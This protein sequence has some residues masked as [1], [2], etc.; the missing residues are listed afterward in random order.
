MPWWI[1]GYDAADDPAVQ[2]E[3]A[4]ID[5]MRSL[6]AALRDLTGGA[7][8]QPEPRLRSAHVVSDLDRA[9]AQKVVRNEAR[10]LGLLVRADWSP[11]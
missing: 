4:T 1:T 9:A 8:L 6:A 3:L 7:R 5:A 10:R 11:R 2:R